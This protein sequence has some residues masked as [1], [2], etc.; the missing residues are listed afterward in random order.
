MAKESTGAAEAGFAV[1]T[2]INKMGLCVPRGGVLERRINDGKEDPKTGRKKQDSVYYR[3]G[4]STPTTV[5]GEINVYGPTWILLWFASSLDPISGEHR[6]IFKGKDAVEKLTEVLR[7]A[8]VD[9]NPDKA[10][11]LFPTS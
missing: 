9:G 4:F 7:T 3:I 8:F 10:L 5:D 2:E 6:Y 11:R 1:A